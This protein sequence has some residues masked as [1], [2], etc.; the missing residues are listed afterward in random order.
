MLP[1]RQTRHIQHMTDF[2][3]KIVVI[4]GA[5][6]G[7]GRHFTRQLRALGARL[8]LTDLE[9]VLLSGAAEDA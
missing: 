2:S 5:G 8:V 4:T 3:E 9:D 1:R 7:F 6:G